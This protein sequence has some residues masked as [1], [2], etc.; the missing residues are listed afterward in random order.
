MYNKKYN[1]SNEFLKSRD[2]LF[3][4]Y[5]NKQCKNLN[6]LKQ[7]E[8]RCPKNSER[9]KL[10]IDN[11]SNRGWSKGLTKETDNRVNKNVESRKNFYKKYG[12]S[13]KGK[14]HSEETKKKISKS[15]LEYNHS[16]NK[17]YSHGKGGYYDNIY[18]MSTWEL[19]YYLYLKDCGE[20]IERC[21]LRFKYTYNNKEHYYTPDF[22]VN[23]K[24]VEIKGRET[25]VDLEKYKVV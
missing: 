19:A 25:E 17:R 13:F 3:C 6:S 18:F 11:L 8:I 15:M 16:S 7:H 10:L 23:G 1:E 20:N 24:I 4:C 5:C 14:H 12:G 9:D 2:D 22:I 21:K